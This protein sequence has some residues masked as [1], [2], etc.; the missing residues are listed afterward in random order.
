MHDIL[1]DALHA[2]LHAESGLL[3]LVK[4]LALHPGRVAREYIEEGKRKRY[5]NPFGFLAL[6]VAVRAAV[7]AIVQPLRHIA[8]STQRTDQMRVFF[9]RHPNV[10]AFLGVPIIA[11]ALWV[12]FRRRGLRYAEILV[13]QCFFTGFM[14]LFDAV[15]L[16]PFFDVLPSV[17]S[18]G[19][20]RLVATLAFNTFAYREMFGRKG[21]L[22]VFT[23]SG[24][25]IAASLF[26]VVC[27]NLA[28]TLYFVLHR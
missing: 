12:F 24:A 3:V 26:W 11:L 22:S 8:G 15:C 9:E 7:N 27:T 10:S 21:V 16:T 13:A 2:V 23:M 19:Y 25:V 5:A 17:N 20:I 28:S 14:T 6:A 1:H 4:G 18:L